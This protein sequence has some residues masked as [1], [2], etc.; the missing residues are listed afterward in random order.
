MEAVLDTNV[1]VSALIS[2]K[3]PPAEMIRAWRAHSF[4]WVTSPALLDE[5]ERALSY[6]RIRQYLTWTEDEIEEFLE[7]IRREARVVHSSQALHVIQDNPEDN[8]VIEAAVE[9]QAG[10]IVTGDY[11]LLDVG[12]YGDI[13]IV[14]PARFAAIIAT[15]LR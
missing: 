15:G 14:T 11:H 5:L 2:P 4:A 12:K 10:Y 8:R 9:G 13:A 7:L 1:V 3:G 6:P